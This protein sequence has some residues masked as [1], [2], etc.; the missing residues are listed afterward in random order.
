MASKLLNVLQNIENDRKS[1][2]NY[3][4]DQGYNISENAAFN[5]LKAAIAPVPQEPTEI[6]TY[7]IPQEYIIH[8]DWIR[9]AEWPDF[10]QVLL[11]A[12]ILRVSNRDNVPYAVLLLKRDSATTTIAA[13]ATMPNSSA[14]GDYIYH[15]GLVMSDGTQY[16]GTSAVTHTWDTTKDIVV[17]DGEFAGNYVYVILYRPD[18]DSIQSTAISTLPIV[19]YYHDAALRA[20]LTSR[21]VNPT[22]YYYGKAAETILNIVIKSY[23]TSP[24]I[25]QTRDVPLYLGNRHALSGLTDLR[26][27]SINCEIVVYNNYSASLFANCSKL[28]HCNLSNL[29]AKVSDTNS[30]FGPIIFDFINCYSLVDIT[31]PQIV[32]EGIKRGHT[33]NLGYNPYLERITTN[34]TEYSPDCVNMI[35]CILNDTSNAFITSDYTYL[36]KDISFIGSYRFVTLPRNWQG[37]NYGPGGGVFHNNIWDALSPTYNGSIT[38]YIYSQYDYN[39]I[40][41]LLDF[42]NLLCFTNANMSSYGV[43]NNSTSSSSII[44]IS[45]SGVKYYHAGTIVL[46]QNVAIRLNFGSINFVNKSCVIHILESLRDLTNE[47]NP[48]YNPNITIS[49][50]NANMLT[51]EE[52][53]IATNKGWNVVVA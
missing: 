29:T 7:N 35:R 41:D 6:P 20:V 28:R 21:F 22:F 45:N 8:E 43:F 17:S 24:E 2:I 48:V 19:E 52:L 42:S 30:L 3:A 9:P 1:L 26:N 44:S 12:P 40:R 13:S 33:I 4:N 11:D 18:T 5:D 51:Q 46:P 14:S 23:C 39:S 25:S 36:K 38:I 10:N 15:N 27:I 37:H 16:T 32:T 53:E 47:T 34:V 50:Y 49:K 31:L